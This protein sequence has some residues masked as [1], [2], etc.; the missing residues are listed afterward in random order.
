[1]GELVLKNCKLYFDGYDISGHTN[2]ITLNYG[3]EL[4]DRTSFG[5]SARKRLAGLTSVELTGSGYFEAGTSKPDT[6]IYPTIGSSSATVLTVCPI[7]NGAVG[8][9]AFSHKAML[10]EYAP[11]GSIGD[12]MSFSFAAFGEGAP[13]V[14]GLVCENSTALSTGLSA[15]PH[16]LGTGTSTQKLYA[17]LHAISV[18]SSAAVLDLTIQCSA[19]SGFSSTTLS[20]QLALNQITDTGG[21]SAQWKSTAASTSK[22]W[23]RLNITSTSTAV[24]AGSLNGIVT[25]GIK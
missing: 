17:A 11:G 21:H 19:S 3:A 18:S 7:S 23:Y 9:R 25:I 22:N 1:M 12:I 14:R 6:A 4:Q 15:T 8:E 10:G 2:N 5:S 20:T 13:L 24:S 16:N